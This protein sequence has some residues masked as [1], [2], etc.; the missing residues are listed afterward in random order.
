MAVAGSRGSLEE[1][2]WDK[3]NRVDCTCQEWLG[4]ITKGGYGN[5]GVSSGVVDYAH[6]VAYRDI[7]GNDLPDDWEVDHKC[8]NRRCVRREHLQGVPPGFN[9]RQ[10]TEVQVARKAQR[11]H[12]AHCGDTLRTTPRG[13]LWCNG[14]RR[15]K[16]AA[17]TQTPPV[18]VDVFGL[19]EGIGGT[20]LPKARAAL[21]VK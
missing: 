16:T 1:R 7:Y 2:F 5:I 12:C 3:V 10:G 8:R 18:G 14:C 13:R 4:A 21:G 9:R 17:T 20:L 11:T 6:R 19:L 15:R